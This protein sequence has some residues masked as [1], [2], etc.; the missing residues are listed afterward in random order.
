MDN[1]SY[2]SEAVT[3]A[4]RHIGIA[5][6]SS[7]K[8]FDYLLRRGYDENTCH[9]AVSELVERGY[10]RDD[11]AAN[12]V[13]SQRTG[14]KQESRQMLYSR[15]LAAGISEQ[16]AESVISKLDGDNDT[17]QYLI[18]ACISSG[19]YDSDDIEGLLAIALRRGYSREVALSAINHFHS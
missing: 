2:H 10:I 1:D 7:G 9:S 5:T 8:I 13:L 18:D 19:R 12:K 16:T 4:I 17:C 6:Y 3:T 14:L 11:K 15:L